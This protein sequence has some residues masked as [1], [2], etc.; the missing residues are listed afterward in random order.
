MSLF[1]P[2]APALPTATRSAAASPSSNASPKSRFLALC[3]PCPPPLLADQPS[4]PKES[5]EGQKNRSPP[6]VHRAGGFRFSRERLRQSIAF[7]CF[8]GGPVPL[9]RRATRAGR[10]ARGGARR[11]P[12]AAR[13]A[14]CGSLGGS[15]TL[16]GP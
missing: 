11:L 10:L 5:S 6:R 3:I 9:P 4:P 16:R 8:G 7:R 12:S 2:A 14:G 15:L 13:P 1:A